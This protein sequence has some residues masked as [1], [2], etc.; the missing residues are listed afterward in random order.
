MRI[1]II[2]L[3]IHLF[4]FSFWT[5]NAQEYTTNVQQ[6]GVKEG[7]AHRHVDALFVDKSGFLWLSCNQQLQRYDGYEFKTYSL[8]KSIGKNTTHI[9]FYNKEWLVLLNSLDEC[10]LLFFNMLTGEFKTKFEKWETNLA[11][12]Y[13]SLKSNSFL[14]D[15]VGDKLY[16]A[17]QAGIIEVNW[18]TGRQKLVVPTELL[19]NKN[20]RVQ[21]IDHKNNIWINSEAEILV[22]TPQQTILKTY[23]KS[24]YVTPKIGVLDLDGKKTSIWAIKEVNKDGIEQQSLYKFKENGDQ[25]FLTSLPNEVQIHQFLDDQIWCLDDFG[26]QVFDTSGDFLFSLNKKDY[27]KRLFANVDFSEIIKDRFGKFYLPTGFGL[28]IIEIQK[29][30][31]T[32]YFS[33]TSEQSVPINNS[34]R[35]IDVKGDSIFVNFEFGGLVLL[36]K[37]NW[38]N[39]KIL[40][41]TSF[42]F[43]TNELKSYSVRPILRDSRDN[44]WRGHDEYLT[45]RVHRF[46]T[47]EALLTTKKTT[48]YAKQIWSLYEDHQGCIWAGF[49]NSLR[50]ICSNDSISA[51]FSHLDLGL[52]FNNVPIYQ[53]QEDENKE[54]WLCTEKGLLVF[55]KSAQKYIAHYHEEGEEQY[56]IPATDIFF[57][58]IDEEQNRWLGT[59]SGLLFWNPKTDEKR[60][61]TR[62][63]GLSNNVIYAVFEDDYN[64]LWL[65]SDYGVMSF[66][67]E[68]FDIQT[69]LPKDGIAQEE[70]NRISHFQ[71][72]DGTIYFG[73]LN[74]VTVF[75]P[76]DFEKSENNSPQM[77]ISDFEILNGKE[78]KLI[79]K[80]AEITKTKTIIFNPDD[81][82]FRL[83]FILPTF[84]ETSKML[85][86]W[87]IEG[88]DEDWNYQKE[89]SIQIGILPYGNHILKIKGQSG[90]GWSPHDLTI[91]IKVLK[92]FYL[93][94]WFIGLSILSFFLGIYFFYKRRTRLLKETQKLLKSEIKKATT[95]IEKDKQTIE[96]QAEELRQLDKVKSRFFAN[97]SHE[98]RTPL[99]L[100]L[101]PISSAINSGQLNNRNFTLLKKAQQ[102]GKDLLKL[103][104][105]ILDLSK[106]ES[107]KMELH[108]KP[109]LLFKL[110]RRIASAFESHA[111]S[112]GIEF[113]FN[114]QGEPHLQINL[115]KE[116]LETILNNL[117]SNAIKFTPKNGEISVNIADLSNVIKITVADTG[118]GIH[119]DD[120]PNVFNRF[121]QSS[122]P[123]AP[124]EGGTGIGLALSQELVHLMGGKIGVTSELGVGTSFLLELPRKEVL[125][126]IQSA[127]PVPKEEHQSAITESSTQIAA[128]TDSGSPR[129]GGKR[130]QTVL[131]VE[132]NHSLR[133]YIKTILE[134]HYQVL[135]AEN[136][137]IAL[138][139]LHSH[140][141]THTPHLILSDIMMPVMDGYQLLNKIKSHETFQHLPIVMLTARA[142]I[143]DKLKALRIGVDDYL[144][145]PFIE[146]ELLARI[147]NLLRNAAERYKFIAQYEP[148][149]TYPTISAE[150][151]IWLEKVENYIRE[152]IASDM[153]SIPNLAHEFA[154]SESSLRRQLKR[155]TG[156]SP[157]KYLQEFKLN[158][159]RQLLENHTYNTVTKV[160]DQVGYADAGA[161]ARVFKKR[162]GKSPSEYLNH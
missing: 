146:D 147:D 32:Q 122:Q 93:Q 144:L 150:D 82:F 134:P 126:T 2:I 68:T 133:D 31:F 55:D 7:L 94:I 106:M 13:D 51:Y 120:V 74:G 61:F 84:E 12:Q 18:Q 49:T 28:N 65:S 127:P 70:F 158:A 98:L 148:E 110:T 30:P 5:L 14:S 40:D 72:K 105:S 15:V 161:F 92:P 34:A 54:L 151:K 114:Y 153:L 154:M 89:N 81:R 58:H 46:D 141:A 11:T 47:T 157:V 50:K 142:D 10:K 67:K 121:Y 1:H 24:S 80:F 36:Q 95:Q 155:L 115:D 125:G 113:E 52:N 91:Q 78:G 88:V 103:V 29:N 64:K 4:F 48:K 85:Y 6:F 22:I 17:N 16:F 112:E 57:M 25:E 75:H 87:K 135:T 117:L 8:P 73:G 101:G 41:T 116:K 123:D 97:V 136:G 60:L 130:E 19:P 109:E 45:K 62:N 69:Y 143:Q 100:M 149:K 21:F 20:D 86:G 107:G 129:A 26:W 162:F 96:I 44:L 59:R 138:E 9:K 79:N 76:K 42:N 63:D 108:E 23:S 156:L 160:A 90:G 139:V 124:T 33:N 35:G 152:N 118:R 145:K 77:L 53:I 128:L 119:P 140:P 111:Q 27:D 102:G 37:S 38:K 43:S 99:T 159:A 104:A 3:L 137:K 56:N 131:I 66:D 132:D 83:K 39:Y 71:E